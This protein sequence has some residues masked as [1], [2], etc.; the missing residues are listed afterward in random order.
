VD[1]YGRVYV[2]DRY[3]VTVFDADHQYK[4]FFITTEEMLCNDLAFDNEGHLYVLTDEN[5]VEKYEVPKP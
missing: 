2:G 4:A 3:G 1:A 5:T